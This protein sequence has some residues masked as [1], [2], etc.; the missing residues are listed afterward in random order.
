MNRYF[1]YFLCAIIL[2]SCAPS[3]QGARSPSSRDVLKAEEIAT[4]GALTAYDAITLKRP[5]FL[6]SRGPKSV[7]GMH[8]ER[9]TQYPSIYVNGL[10][11]YGELDRLRDILV[12][13]IKEIRYFDPPSANLQFGLGNSA[14][15]ILVTLNH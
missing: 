2:S 3:T 6:R 14:G 12:Q 4:T 15:V 10:L 13:D 11:F 8:D 1:L 9:S 7:Q 5:N